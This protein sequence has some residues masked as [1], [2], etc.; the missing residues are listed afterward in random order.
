MFQCHLSHSIT[1]YDSFPLSLLPAFL[2][3]FSFPA[4]L[5]L[6]F[7]IFLSLQSFFLPCFKSIFSLYSFVSFFSLPNFFN[8][9]LANTYSELSHG[10]ALGPLFPAASPHFPHHP[11]IQYAFQTHLSASASFPSPLPAPTLSHLLT[12]PVAG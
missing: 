7:F 8:I 5:F 6:Y 12:P 10:Q 9:V 3:I 4:Y 11:S 1:S 2:I